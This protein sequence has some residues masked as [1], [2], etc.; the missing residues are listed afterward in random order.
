MAKKYISCEINK[1]FEAKGGKF[2]LSLKPLEE[3]H[4]IE[5]S[6]SYK[7]QYN[8]F[9][10]NYFLKGNVLGNKLIQEDIPNWAKQGNKIKFCYSINNGW[11]N[12]NQDDGVEIINNDNE[13][14][15]FNEV[16]DEL[17]DSFDPTELEKELNNQTEDPT[18]NRINNMAELYAKIFKAIHTHDYLKKLDTG[19]KIDIATSFFIQLNR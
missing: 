15:T 9:T 8:N 13:D 1:V 18:L 6:N 16:V 12:I 10:I 17:D 14:K 3:N 2:G 19:L 4:D 5:N 11:V 7:S